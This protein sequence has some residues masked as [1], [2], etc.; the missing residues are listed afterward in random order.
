MGAFVRLVPVLTVTETWTVPSSSSTVKDCPEV[1]VV[2][3][4][5]GMSLSLIVTL[6][7]LSGVVAGLYPVPSFM[8]TV[9]SELAS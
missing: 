7:E 6:A 9:R 5:V 2:T 1:K 8:V 4:P 3:V